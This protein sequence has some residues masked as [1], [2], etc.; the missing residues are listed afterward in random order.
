MKNLVLGSI[1]IALVGTTA[2]A[3]LQY[4]SPVAITTN[5]DGSAVVRGA[6]GTAAN[7]ANSVEYIGCM[8]RVYGSATETWCY[9]RD[10]AGNNRVCRT[11][12]A[13]FGQTMASINS[14]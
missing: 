8:L 4:D 3:G 14:D 11:T 6:M 5:P 9:A 10:A 2:V 13:A 1:F 12:Q 7:S